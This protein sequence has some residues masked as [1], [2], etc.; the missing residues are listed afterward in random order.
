MAQ[1][2]TQETG[3]EGTN[4]ET[5]SADTTDEEAEEATHESVS[6]YACGFV[7]LNTFFIFVAF[8]FAP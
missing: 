1:E 4:S 3:A 2:E 7:S 5:P 8:L 6:C